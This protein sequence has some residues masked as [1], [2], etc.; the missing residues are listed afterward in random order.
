[1]L[2]LVPVINWGSDFCNTALSNSDSSSLI[3]KMKTGSHLSSSNLPPFR[4]TKLNKPVYNVPKNRYLF[5]C[6]AWIDFGLSTSEGE[7]RYFY[8]QRKKTT[9]LFCMHAGATETFSYPL[10]LTTTLSKSIQGGLTSLPVIIYIIYKY[11]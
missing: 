9:F 8:S 1:M 2:I 4:Q 5:E 11:K 10:F 7:V 3:H 6:S